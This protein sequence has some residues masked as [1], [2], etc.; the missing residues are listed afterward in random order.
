MVKNGSY[1]PGSEWPF[2]L[3][4]IVT[5]LTMQNHDWTTGFPKYLQKNSRHLSKAALL[6]LL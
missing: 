4:V 5:I 1:F 3:P 2:D 6:T